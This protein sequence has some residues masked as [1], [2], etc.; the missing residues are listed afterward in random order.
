[1]QSQT[2]I[3]PAARA[4]IADLCKELTRRVQRT[5]TVDYGQTECGQYHDAALCVES[6]PAGSWGHPGSLVSI[7]ARPEIPGG[8]AVLAAD[9]SPVV[10]GVA[11]GQAV[12]AARFEAVRRYREMV[13][14]HEIVSPGPASFAKHVGDK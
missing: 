2:T 10:E 4:L 3:T 14:H 11:L 9:G 1:M 7:L 12:Q 6:L 13:G 8:F 5:V